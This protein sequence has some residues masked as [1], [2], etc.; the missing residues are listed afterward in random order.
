MLLAAFHSDPNATW[1]VIAC[2]FP[3]LTAEP[4]ELLRESYRPP[5]TC[6]LNLEGFCE[7][8]LGIW[9]PEA[10]NRLEENVKRGRSGPKSVVRDLG[11]TQIKAHASFDRSI[12]NV[13]TKTE[14]D[15]VLAILEDLSQENP[16][17]Y[18][19]E[20]ALQISSSSEVG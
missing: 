12:W 13:N 11:G 5:V 3:L 2:D 1:L 20:E 16:A 15:S 14:W 10:L 9:S 19:K 6:F 8:L 18:G 7:P 4:L 17:Q